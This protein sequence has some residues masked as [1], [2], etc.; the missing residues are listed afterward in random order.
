MKAMALLDDR[1]MCAMD[2]GEKGKAEREERLRGWGRKSNG[3]GERKTE[4]GN[5]R[6][7]GERGEKRKEDYGVGEKKIEQVKLREKG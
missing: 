4:W 6:G 2:G 5:M 7:K 1:P 3:A